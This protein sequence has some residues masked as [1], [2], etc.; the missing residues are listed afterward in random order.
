M[1]VIQIPFDQSLANVTVA[2]GPLAMPPTTARTDAAAGAAANPPINGHAA[3]QP[4][5]R[6]AAE[7]RDESAASALKTLQS[8]EQQLQH[9]DAKLDEEFSSIGVQ[10]TAAATQLAKQALGSDSSLVEERVAHFANILLRQVHPSQSAVIFVNPD[11]VTPL[12]SWLSQVEYEAI[13]IQADAT[14]Q[15]GDC[16]IESNGK[17]FLASL[18]SFLDAAAKRMSTARGES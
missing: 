7:S 1:A 17:G 6:S 14:V 13:E 3:A 11:C 4:S 12:E 18:E 2:R 9:L 5:A 16:R 8:I 10:L 15:P